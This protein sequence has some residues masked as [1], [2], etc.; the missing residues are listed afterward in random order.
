MRGFSAMATTASVN[1]VT[2]H[3]RVGGATR[4]TAVS[5]PSQPFGKKTT[6]YGHL[7][8]LST[9]CQRGY[10][11]RR[12]RG[13]RIGGGL[14]DGVSAAVTRASASL[15]SRSTVAAPKLRIA[16]VGAGPCGL[17]TALALRH[18]GMADVTVFDKQPEIRPALGAAFN[19]NGGAAV[20][21]KLGI[22]SVFRRINNPM[23]RVRSRRVA[24]DR[25]Q[26][27]DID[28]E[29]LIQR[30]AADSLVSSTDGTT[31]CGTVMRA[32]L[33]RALGKAP[34]ER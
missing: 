20:L 8:K 24:R 21:D 2:S 13:C 15:F 14:V 3:H 12:P 4:G 9:G 22:L 34:A 7:E 6:F 32:D 25:T 5:S 1:V 26:L 29:E 17:T 27:M 28:I 19:L 11:H 31:L 16:V 18:F 33:L 23:R 30:D 10:H